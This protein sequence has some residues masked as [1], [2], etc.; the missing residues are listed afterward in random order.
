MPVFIF[1][2]HFRLKSEGISSMHLCN[3][4]RDFLRFYENLTEK[5][6]ITNL[7]IYKSFK[8]ITDEFEGKPRK[9]ILKRKMLIIKW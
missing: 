4:E 2:K 1:K 5:K 6:I 7:R 9:K 3:I 8:E